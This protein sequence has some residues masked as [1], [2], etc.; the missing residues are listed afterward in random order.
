MGSAVTKTEIYK[1]MEAD[2]KELQVGA[3]NLEKIQ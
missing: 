1:Q 3:K 2:M